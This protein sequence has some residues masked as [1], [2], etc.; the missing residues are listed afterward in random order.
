MAGQSRRNRSD[1]SLPPGFKW[2]GGVPPPGVTVYP[3]PDRNAP[4]PGV[5]VYPAPDRNAPPP[6]VTITAAPGPKPISQRETKIMANN[7]TSTLES[8][9]APPWAR[10]AQASTL[11]PVEAPP[12]AT[13]PKPISQQET[14]SWL[15]KV[16]GSDQT[17]Q[18]SQPTTEPAP[19]NPAQTE[20]PSYPIP[21]SMPGFTGPLTPPEGL[22][23]KNQLI[24]SAMQKAREGK[25]LT[26]AEANAV[27][28][29]KASRQQ[30][31]QQEVNKGLQT[32]GVGVE[33]VPSYNPQGIQPATEM[34]NRLQEG[35]LSPEQ[36]GA[37]EKKLAIDPETAHQLET[38]L[39]HYS[40]S[41]FGP[42][43][44]AILARTLLGTLNLWYSPAMLVLRG[45]GS[46]EYGAA[47]EAAGLGQEAKAATEAGKAVTERASQLNAAGDAQG[48]QELSNL[49][50]EHFAKAKLAK[51]A[52]RETAKFISAVHAANSAIGTKF[53]VSMAAQAV[54][55]IRKGEPVP[56]VANS[57]GFAGMAFLTA[58]GFG[59]AAK[60]Y[61]EGG[62]P[63]PGFEVRPATPEEMAAE[64]QKGAPRP[65][66]T[67]QV[68]PQ[69][70]AEVVK[71]EGVKKPV[72]AQV[73]APKPTEPPPGVEVQPAPTEIKPVEPAPAQ[74]KSAAPAKPAQEKSTAASFR[75]QLNQIPQYS[76]A[77]KAGLEALVKAS[78]ESEGKSL[79]QYIRE[80]G[81]Q[82]RYQG[83]KSPSEVLG[84]DALLQ[85][86]QRG[87]YLLPS[88]RNLPVMG[89]RVHEQML[90]Q[91]NLGTPEEALLKGAIRYGVQ[92]P[93]AYFEAGRLNS[94]ARERI[95]NHI[96]SKLPSA[97]KIEIEWRSPNHGFSEMPRG[98]ALA[99]LR[100]NHPLPQ[101]A[102]VGVLYQE[103]TPAPTFF[104][105]VRRSVED[106]PQSKFTGDQLISYLR[107]K[108]GIKLEELQWSG[109]EDLAKR[110]KLTKDEV[111]K[112]IDSADLVPKEVMLGG[113]RQ[114]QNLEWR[115]EGENWLAGAP[116]WFYR[117]KQSKS[118]NFTVSGT[119]GSATAPTLEAA[120][121][122]AQRLSN[123]WPGPQPKFGQ[124]T[125]SGP[126]K[127]YREI[128]LTRPSAEGSS[129]ATPHWQQRN[130]IAHMRVDDRTD[131]EGK[132]VLFVDETQSD[133]HQ[134]RHHGEEVPA[135]PFKNWHELLMKRAL[136]E[137][138]KG[139]YDKLDWPTGEQNAQLYDLSKKIRSVTWNDRTHQLR[140]YD[141]YGRA[142]IRETV[143]PEKL[144]DF[145][146]KSGAE[147]LQSRESE[148][149]RSKG[150]RVHKIEG[151]D[152]KVGGEWA[153]NLYDRMIPQF[154]SKYTKK[155]GGKVGTDSVETS[156]FSGIITKDGEP[157]QFV[158]SKEALERE[159]QRHRQ[160]NPSS[161]YAAETLTK[162]GTVHSLTITPAIRQAIL[163]EGQPLFQVGRG[164]KGAITFED[165]ATIVHIFKGGDFSTAVHELMHF[166]SMKKAKPWQIKAFENY[167]KKPIKDFVAKDWEI[168][169]RL[170]ERFV[171]DGKA[172][173]EALKKVFA[174]FAK[175][176]RAIYKSLKGS[177]IWREVPK[178]M[179]DAFAG[180]F[181]KEPPKET[182]QAK[183]AGPPIRREPIESEAEREAR[184][185]LA[186]HF[187]R[188]NAT[189]LITPAGKTAI[190]YKVVE[191]D[192]LLPS[193]NPETFAPSP[194][195]PQYVQ[196]R[197]YNLSKDAQ[198][199]V[200]D[201]AKK[202]DPAFTINTNPDAVNGPP[203]VTPD[204]I[205]LGGNS[206]V[207]STQR[208]Y[209]SGK[210]KIYKDAL[211]RQAQLFGLKSSEVERFKQPVLVRAL[212]SEPRNQEEARKI[213]RDLNKPF[214]GALG[215]NE[216]AVSAGR[217]MTA[218]VLHV[219]QDYVEMG[220]PDGTLRDALR[221]HPRQILNALV[222][223]GVIT[224]R[225]RPALTD[226]AGGIS[227]D[228]K[229]F[230]EKAILGS[231][232]DDVAL[233]EN[234]PRSA[235]GK[236]ET[237]LPSLFKVK[238]RAD[239]WDVTP[240]VREALRELTEIS[241]TGLKLSDYLAQRGM[242]GPKRGPAVEAMIR[243]LDGKRNAVRDG[244]KQFAR[245]ASQ[246]IQG[247]G[248]LGLTQ[249]PEPHLSFN[250][251]FGAK[252]S[253]QEYNDAIIRIANQE[254]QRFESP[255]STPEKKP[256]TRKM[257]GPPLPKKNQGKSS[258]TSPAFLGPGQRLE[259]LKSSIPEVIKNA[260]KGKTEGPLGKQ[261]LL[262]SIQRLLDI[263]TRVGRYRRKAALGVFK[264]KPEVIRTRLANDIPTIAHELAHALHKLWWGTT[265]KG[266]LLAKPLR[267]FVKE[268]GPIATPGT[269]STEGFAEYVRKYLT[270]RDE[271]KRVAPK[272]TKFFEDKLS[273]P[274]NAPLKEAIDTAQ[275]KI[276]EYLSQDPVKKIL[277]HI[278]QEDGQKPPANFHRLYTL[279]IDRLR[280]IQV[281]TGELAKSG[282][283]VSP[284]EDAYNA[285]RLFAGWV[286]K[287][288][289]FLEY[290]TFNPRTHEVTGPSLQSILRPWEGRMDDLRAY[291]VARRTIE[292]SKQGIE[293]G[294]DPATAK[295]AFDSLD[296]PELR[297][298]AAELDAYSDSLLQYQRKLG[299]LSDEQYASIK[300]MNK[301]YTPLYREMEESVGGAPSGS[302]GKTFADL[303]SPVKRMKGSARLIVDPL[304]GYIKNTYSFINS[305]ERNRVAE[306]LVSQAQRAEGA[307]KWVE[308]I[309]APMKPT[310]FVLAEIRK[311]LAD[312]GFDLT[313]EGLETVATVFRPSSFGPK[314]DN[315]ISV[316]KDGKRSFYQVEPELY[317]A[318]KALD[319]ESMPILVRLLSIPAKTLR[320]GATM[321]GPEFMMRNPLRDTMDAFFQSEYHFVPVWDTARGLFHALKRDDLYLEWKR[322][323][324]EHAAL[325]SLDRKN[326][327]KKLKAMTDSQVKW[328]V[329]HPLN[330]L[331][332]LSEF[333]E[334]A[335]RLGLYS[336]AKKQ[337]ATI[338]QAA[339]ESREGTLDFA[340]IGA[341]GRVPNAIIA[342][343][344]ANVQGA[345]KFWR[346]HK[347]FPLRSLLRGLIGAT[348]PTILLYLLNR[349]NKEWQELP[350]WRRDFF[351]NIP[352]DGTPLHKHTHFLPI[353][354]PFIWGLVYG[355]VPERVMQF[356]DSK[357][358]SAFDQ[359]ASDIWSATS[360]GF[361]PTG[362][363]PAIEAWGNKSLFTGRRLVP[364]RLQD[365]SPEYRAKPYTSEFSKK[366]A[367]ALAKLGIHVSPINIDNSI[368]GYFGGLG[369]DL[370][371]APSLVL[372]RSLNKPSPEWADYP[373]LK[374]FAVRPPGQGSLSVEKFYDRYEELS[375]KFNTLRF[376][377][378]FPNRIQ[379]APKMTRKELQ[380][381]AR[382]RAFYKVLLQLN[383]RLR[384]LYSNDDPPEKKRKEIDATNLRIVNLARRAMRT[385]A[386][387]GPSR[388]GIQ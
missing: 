69:V 80:N 229:A 343:F 232:I 40:R 182:A 249:N 273:E 337:G 43:N 374:S 131:T 287:A 89:N 345:E 356:I 281:V 173:T 22:V 110:G 213:A 347:E 223:N 38:Q 126:K 286:G 56:A 294:I 12:W 335:T 37:L 164:I 325:V 323:G 3:A 77:H 251:A 111:L 264:V 289:H 361:I 68:E 313:D 144:A 190:S 209:R 116:G 255:A 239:T 295:L 134:A 9:Q 277:G 139:G 166:W 85:K 359:L 207:M 202:Y 90:Q 100:S 349:K 147:K 272:F 387:L 136:D 8:V 169:A 216:R 152:L 212:E 326:L 21:Q 98:E 381:F 184:S 338:A 33:G 75:Q 39:G 350:E 181:S 78:A 250:D 177:P 322:S 346:T 113:P 180:F 150:G 388:D 167:R 17:V 307:G 332:A 71:P 336:R 243:F 101:S 314:G 302:S 118:G 183:P 276:A 319:E 165:G 357:D 120:K 291:L 122:E 185:R 146:G 114:E 62:R 35:I 196:E 192:S 19:P 55:S 333:G 57:L 380:E 233:L 296:S 133:W 230:I 339:M 236:I 244:F 235:I 210:G 24:A 36:M 220:G 283:K 170:G 132:K 82:F 64:A 218:D 241:R 265:P 96:E 317:R 377:A 163:S 290:G 1:N 6:G 329:L 262:D 201:Q 115:K 81:L 172:P 324:A 87:G 32:A 44:R 310:C 355:D 61:A 368:Y 260:V 279:A 60:A 46:I 354:K 266:R 143:P 14:N 123:L 205:V 4:P 108:P 189:E 15:D 178:E 214:T 257:A 222:A 206:R 171:Y 284:E 155:W 217:S 16:L 285:A 300:E 379:N 288:D 204:G 151:L 367:M 331:G 27:Q 234:A 74:A 362:A 261:K 224:E 219:V 156:I 18:Q 20:Q 28:A 70:K 271:A 102:P 107:K 65:E 92:G 109:L 245:D 127:N 303:F 267:K 376:G 254:Q 293:T 59:A 342:F 23:Y 137:A 88:G 370:A 148:G 268:L 321:L 364:E 384:I 13:G 162:A 270:N 327:R 246:D 106:L 378:R 5:T 369:R 258:G 269:K 63:T 199:R 76:E 188:G 117:I 119:N 253:K 372:T 141:E 298:T 174:Q 203:V 97:K 31:I 191:A 112:Q 186:G 66:I 385:G 79:D 301:D 386:P 84:P 308:K 247:Q 95:A 160:R 99:E 45:L 280:P 351:W 7:P 231:V 125:L 382:L 274:E 58:L 54:D 282:A 34:I 25:Q 375:Q 348:I 318:L 328:T 11:Q 238:V 211:L 47:K 154:L 105:S 320:L 26:E 365:L 309:P 179:A 175:W 145:V 304:E 208:L 187:Q 73:E 49:A 130:V 48:A 344:N 221:S 72:E 41:T 138:V 263:P 215:V 305:A 341:K 104:S 140:A 252:I 352:T 316:M 10:R 275:K 194:G 30:A 91:A 311:S 197:A 340:R 128:L 297:K 373:L 256:G 312:Q 227:A 94:A 242:F 121:Q 315:I 237:S 195:Y 124:Y 176:M 306:L 42:E 193:H 278:A 200:I 158:G 358:P 248:S 259:S 363:I 83:E 366:M 159:L 53:S 142:P 240:I 353:P 360:P 383:R 157:V 129:Y 29:S 50:N 52:Q 135:A 161:I 86:Q 198:A 149:V 371:E 330:A 51:Q 292:K 2:V 334:T 103:A 67:G 153:K 299:M 226:G 168:L 93:T 225:E 228:G